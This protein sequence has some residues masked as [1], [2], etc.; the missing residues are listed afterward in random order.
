MTALTS[1]RARILGSRIRQY[2]DTPFE[3]IKGEGVWLYDIQGRRYLD[4]Y[5]NVPHVGHCHPEVVDAVC[6]QVAILNTNTRYLYGSIVDYAERLVATMPPSLSVC[7]FTCTGSEANDLAWRLA[8][9]FS[10]ADGVITTEHAYH[11]NTTFLDSID[12]SSIERSRPRPS[13]WAT[14]PAPTSIPYPDWEFQNAIDTIHSAGHRLGAFFFDST[15]CSDGIHM[16]GQGSLSNAVDRVRRSGGLLI[17][18]EVQAGL[19]RIGTHLW[20]WEH[21]GVLPDIATMGKPIGNGMPLGVVVTRRDILEAFQSKERYFNTF[22][23]NPVSCSAGMAVLEVLMREKLQENARQVGLK[24][25]DALTELATRHENIGEIRGLG[26]LLGVEIVKSRKSGDAAPR[27]ARWLLN[28]MFRRGVLVGLT[29]PNRNAM[30]V[31]KI[32][33][34]MVFSSANVDQLATTM[35]QSLSALKEAHVM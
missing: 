22:A 29:G 17:A 35:D 5:N 2:Y 24:M 27:E 7:A 13:W 21:L 15:F 19:G 9:C 4:A 10:N 31:I 8:R 26:F 28:D 32:R 18:D 14:V 11:G 1:R 12:G 30:S 3:P 16:P 33:P 25:K 6:R 34:P 23:G 20:S